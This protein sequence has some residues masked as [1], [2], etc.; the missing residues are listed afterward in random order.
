MRT[1]YAARI[2]LCS[3]LLQNFHDGVVDQ[4]LLFMSVRKICEQ[5][6]KKI[7][8]PF[9]KVIVKRVARCVENN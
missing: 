9:N 4:Q 6:A 3:W 2:L 8:M 5:G 7:L 1:D